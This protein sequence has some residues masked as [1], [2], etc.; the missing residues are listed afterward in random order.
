MLELTLDV[1]SIFI[2]E[3]SVSRVISQFLRSEVKV[4][5]KMDLTKL[6]QSLMDQQLLQST[7]HISVYLQHVS[8]LCSTVSEI[9][10]GLHSLA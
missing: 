3:T 9:R 2:L 8:H 10:E 7:S 4:A 6:P 5:I 1:K